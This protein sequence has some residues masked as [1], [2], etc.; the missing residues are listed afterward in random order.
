[1]ASRTTTLDRMDD[2]VG[3][4]I[5]NFE[6][7]HGAFAD[8]KLFTGPS[9]HFHRR[10]LEV[11]RGHAT[12][13]HAVV[14][15]EFLELLYAMLSAWG[16]HRMGPGNTRLLDLEHIAASFAEV[17]QAVARLDRLAIMDLDA[18]DVP[19]IAEQIWAVLA[20]LRVGIGET[21]L[22]ANTK[23]LHHVLPDLVPPVDRE[24][25]LRFFYGQKGLARGDEATFLEIYPRFARM[26][27]AQRGNIQR[28]VAAGEYMNTSQSKVLDNVIVGWVRSNLRPATSEIPPAAT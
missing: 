7:Y 21:K 11:R 6:R 1:M 24:Y 19:G 2:R 8:Q 3:D 16:M 13:A 23:A 12:S 28:L 10:A 18:A 14:D 26:A 17:Q 25:T 20:R 22:V 5:A 27:R 9:L 4:V 15:Q